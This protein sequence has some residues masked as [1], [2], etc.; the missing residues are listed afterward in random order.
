MLKFLSLVTRHFNSVVNILFFIVQ[1][2][3]KACNILLLEILIE[4]KILP[5]CKVS[6]I[7]LS[8]EDKLCQHDMYVNK[9]D[10]VLNIIYVNRNG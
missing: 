3:N 1:Y 4:M 8:I 10:N 6:I 2:V 5:L 9:A 7:M